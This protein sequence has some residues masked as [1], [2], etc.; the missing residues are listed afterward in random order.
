MAK[1][2]TKKAREPKPK[3]AHFAGMEPPSIPEIDRA[4]ENYCA[5]RDE[6]MRLT[7]DETEKKTILRALMLK[8]QLKNYEYDGKEVL[9]DDE[10][11]VKV[12]KKK[13]EKE[14]GDGE[15]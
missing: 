12:R 4:A 10:P 3:Q 2:K 7:T 9:I 5:V 8:N 6:R 15:E 1:A 11:T 14:D 13:V